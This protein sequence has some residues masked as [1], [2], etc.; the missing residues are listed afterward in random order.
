[1]PSKSKSPPLGNAPGLPHNS[2]HTRRNGSNTRSNSAHSRV[3]GISSNSPGKQTISLPTREELYTLYRGYS[4]KNKPK[5]KG[6]LKGIRIPE[7][8]LRGASLNAVKIQG[9]VNTR[10]SLPSREELL[11]QFKQYSAKN[12]VKKSSKFVPNDL[13]IEM[14]DIFFNDVFINDEPVEG[15]PGF[16]DEKRRDSLKRVKVDQGRLLFL[17]PELEHILRKKFSNDKEVDNVLK[18][19]KEVEDKYLNQFP[20]EELKIKK[21]IRIKYNDYYR[22]IKNITIDMFGPIKTDI[23]HATKELRDAIYE[24]APVSKKNE[25]IDKYT[26]DIRGYMFSTYA[27]NIH[28]PLVRLRLEVFYYSLEFGVPSHRTTK[29]VSE[30]KQPIMVAS[31]TKEVKG[32][33]VPTKDKYHYVDLM[34]EMDNFLFEYNEQG[35]R[36]VKVINDET[37]EFA[38]LFKL[39]EIRDKYLSAF[40]EEKDIKRDISIIYEIL[41]KEVET[42]DTPFGE[43]IIQAKKELRD[44]FYGHYDNQTFFTKKDEI[45]DKYE[46]DIQ[47][48]ITSVDENPHILLILELYYTSLAFSYR[49]LRTTNNVQLRAERR[50]LLETAQKNQLRIASKSKGVDGKM[51][52]TNANKQRVDS[53]KSAF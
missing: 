31:E 49:S 44:A 47:T 14:D 26:K 34:L 16:S 23:L 27:H 50:L 36:R 2:N 12:K 5:L 29:H 7:R 39:K 19:L 48:R 32:N 46:K 42:R 13:M 45:I 1:M 17:H 43:E 30:I 38:Y 11:N 9:Q 10:R 20:E 53:R 41:C 35:R 25:I 40:P 51:E 18:N 3:N 28:L 15:D 37:D 22:I 33:K 21:Y 6:T 4:R 24:R 52:L 8:N